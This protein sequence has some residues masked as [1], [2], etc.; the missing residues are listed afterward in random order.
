MKRPLVVLFV[1]FAF[2]PRTN[3]QQLYAYRDSVPEGYDF[4]LYLPPGIDTC[5]APVPTILFLHG[6]SLCGTDLNDVMRYGTIDALKRGLQLDAIVIAPQSQEV[7]WIPERLDPVTDFVVRK[8]PC[9]TN[10]FYVIG[11]SMGG[12]GTLKMVHNHPDRIA[13]ALAMCG[14]YTEP[15]ISG[16]P[17]V[18]LWIIHGFRDTVTAV[19]YSSSLVKQLYASGNGTRLIYD[20]P[21]C[22]HAELA[23]MFYLPEMYDWLFKH[24]LQDPG[25]PVNLSYTYTEA[26]MNAAYGRLDPDNS[27]NLIP[28]R[29]PYIPDRLPEP[30]PE[31]V[32]SSW[33]EIPSILDWERPLLLRLREQWEKQ[34]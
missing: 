6:R 13:A 17:E 22:G 4:L 3:A 30:E 10:R 2:F 5:T 25:R 27:I 28:K 19:S 29:P 34:R 20:Q 15:S 33:D 7:G 8:F 9:D 14:G 32:I 1:L 16:L 12:W 26:K 23:R 31:P 18:P 21:V 11:M 24:S